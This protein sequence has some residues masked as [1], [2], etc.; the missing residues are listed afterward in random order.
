[1]LFGL[2]ERQRKRK[3]ETLA[4]PPLGMELSTGPG[5]PGPRDRDLS[6]NQGLDA[7]HTELPRCPARGFKNAEPTWNSKDMCMMC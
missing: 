5:R 3:R 6:W 4:D 2:G 1:M 7:K